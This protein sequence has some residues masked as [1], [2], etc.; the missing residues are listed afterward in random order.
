MTI[1]YIK[2]NLVD[3]IPAVGALN[4]QVELLTVDEANTKI[5][6]LYVEVTDAQGVVISKKPDY[7][8]E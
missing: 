5:D 1:A 7:F 8:I 2:D 4:P 3:V 6:E